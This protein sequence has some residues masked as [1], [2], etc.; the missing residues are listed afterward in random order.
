[1][2]PSP[3]ELNLRYGVDEALVAWPVLAAKSGR[4]DVLPFAVVRMVL[5]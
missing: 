3:A 5:P 2:S 4:L 1:M